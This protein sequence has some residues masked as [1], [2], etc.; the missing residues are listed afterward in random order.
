MAVA[1]IVVDTFM[2]RINPGRPEKLLRSVIA[3]KLSGGVHIAIGTNAICLKETCPDIDKFSYGRYSA[4]VHIDCIKFSPQPVVFFRNEKKI[5]PVPIL[6][7]G[8]FWV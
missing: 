7:D 5:S 3:E 2:G 4:G 8:K 1:C 6:K